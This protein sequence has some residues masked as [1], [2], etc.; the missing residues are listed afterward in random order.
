EDRPGRATFAVAF[1][2]NARQAAGNKGEIVEGGPGARPQG[3]E[4]ADAIAAQLGLDLDVL[5]D[6]GRVGAAWVRK[7]FDECFTRGAFGVKLHNATFQIS[8]SLRSKFQSFRP[9]RIF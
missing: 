5:N 9:E 4:T 2:G 1:Q 8:I 7:R 6:G 3:A